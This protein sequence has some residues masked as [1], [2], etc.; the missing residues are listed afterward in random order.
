MIIQGL[1]ADSN[2][3]NVFCTIGIT[4]IPRRKLFVL[5]LVLLTTVLFLGYYSTKCDSERLNMGTDVVGAFRVVPLKATPLS[6]KL[7]SSKF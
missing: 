4:E 7:L 2:Y 6:S 1:Y 3:V 5:I